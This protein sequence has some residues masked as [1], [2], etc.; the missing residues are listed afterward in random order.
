MLITINIHSIWNVL[1]SH[2]LF[3]LWQSGNW[4]SATNTF[5]STADLKSDSIVLTYFVSTDNMKLIPQA[6]QKVDNE[7]NVIYSL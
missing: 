6:S 5:Q 7:I 2:I 3:W 1:N 4:C